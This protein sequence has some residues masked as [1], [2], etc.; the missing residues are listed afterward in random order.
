[1]L[2]G[3]GIF[4]VVLM[5]AC[6][7]STT[8]ATTPSPVIAKVGTQVV[9]QSALDIR[10][11]SALVQLHQGGA[12]TPRGADDPMLQKV[13]AG[14]LQSLITDAVIAQ[15]AGYRHLAVTDSQVESEIKADE[16][17]AGGSNALQTQLA[18]AG[19]SMEQLRDEIRSRENEANL[20]NS[21]AQ[22]RASAAQSALDGG[23]AFSDVVARYSD[24]SGSAANGG[25]MGAIALTTLNTSDTTFASSVEKLQVGQ[26]TAKP[27]RDRAGYE[28][29]RV[30]AHSGDSWSVHR[31]LISAPQPYT[32]INRPKWF[33]DSLLDAVAQL[34]AAHQLTVY[35][36]KS[37]QPCSAPAASQSASP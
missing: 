17:A 16:S 35:I 27:V 36:E 12:P 1:M 37:V 8:S 2:R 30:D 5:S 14:V 15:E 6:G 11:K 32:V 26:T 18:Q 21:F 4:V 13:R 24:D 34:C 29:L 25:D 23:M 9:R 28:I 33:A 31:I 19:G 20:E 3:I 10:L 7:S 22:E